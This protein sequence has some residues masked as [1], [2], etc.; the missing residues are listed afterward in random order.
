MPLPTSRSNLPAHNDP[1]I[2]AAV[3][4]TGSIAEIQSVR[5]TAIRAAILSLLALVCV[6]ALTAWLVIGL[7]LSEI[8]FH[9]A[10][11]EASDYIRAWGAL[12]VFASIGLMVLHS[13]VPVPAE[14]IAAANCMVFGPYWGFLITWIGAMVAA[15]GA[16]AVSRYLGRP[17]LQRILSRQ[18]YLRIDQWAAHGG[19]PTLIVC[20]LIPLVSFNV[21]NYAAGLMNVSWW[22]FIWT[23]AIGIIPGT[24]ITILVTESLLTGGI[25]VTMLC[26]S[27]AVLV[28]FFWA[29]RRHRHSAESR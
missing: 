18:A 17:L 20:R 6:I 4:G 5:A 24:L 1:P 26:L 9:E 7:G 14:I 15:A 2:D 29:W 28:L 19:V 27:A 12:A 11:A 10:I 13:V 25:A 22:T 16:F 23:T 8:N 21:I 3:D